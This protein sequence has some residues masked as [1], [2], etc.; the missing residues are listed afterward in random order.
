MPPKNAAGGTENNGGGIRAWF[1]RKGKRF[2]GPTRIG[3][4]AQADADKDRQQM[5]ETNVSMASLET[6]VS[7]LKA[8]AAAAETP[9]ERNERAWTKTLRR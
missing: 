8:A 6:V 7:E 5:R 9:A 4:N 2:T 1:K 3:V